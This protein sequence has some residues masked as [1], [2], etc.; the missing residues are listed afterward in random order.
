M[1]FFKTIFLPDLTYKSINVVS[2][3]FKI[4]KVALATCK[5]T[6]INLYFFI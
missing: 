1:D 4:K 2:Y 5:K 3:I 6:R